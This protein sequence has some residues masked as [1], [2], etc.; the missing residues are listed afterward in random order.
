[1]FQQF[2]PDFNSIFANVDINCAEPT[3]NA[4]DLQIH[5]R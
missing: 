3:Q 2:L 1:M 5:N 4:I